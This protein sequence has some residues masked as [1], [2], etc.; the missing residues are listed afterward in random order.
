VAWRTGG[1]YIGWAPLPPQIGWRAGIG[2][3][4]GKFS[5]D[6]IPAQR[7]IFVRDRNFLASEIHRNIIIAP[8]N[9]TVIKITKNVTRIVP[10]DGRIV[11]R[12]IS[13]RDVERTTGKRVQVVRVKEVGKAGELRA[14]RG[15]AGEVVIFRPKIE[16]APANVTPK[17]FQTLEGRHKAERATYEEKQKAERANLG[18]QHAIEQQG[19]TREEAAMRQRHAEERATI[20]EKQR[21]EAANLNRRQKLEGRASS[22]GQEE[23]RRRQQ[24]ETSTLQKR[25]QVEVTRQEQRM[26]AEQGAA[27]SRREEMLR[28]QD[29]E[30]KALESE[31]AQQARVL[32]NRQAQERAP[33]VMSSEKAKPESRQARERTPQVKSTEKAKSEQGKAQGKKQ[34]PSVQAP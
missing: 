14:A 19:D 4:F 28:R 3:E 29:S 16:R 11:D 18:R 24:A 30:R 25:Q 34:A 7:W 8:R 9:V 26:K 31:N 27:G 6:L 5:I 10:V 32:E 15:R 1:G 33:Q 12:S 22:F 2:L 17:Q 13:V 20:Q 21:A 23:E